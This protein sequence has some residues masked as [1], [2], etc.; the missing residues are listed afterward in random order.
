MDTINFKYVLEIYREKNITRAAKK[1]YVSQPALSQALNRIEKLYGIKIFDK[2]YNVTKSGEIFIK[3]AEK[4]N[5]N[6]VD[7]EEELNMCEINIGISQFYVKYLLNQILATMSNINPQLKIHVKEDISRY[8]EVDFARGELDIAF[9]PTPIVNNLNYKILFNEKLLLCMPMDFDE[10]YL[11]NNKVKVF[12][13]NK[14]S[15]LRKISDEIIEKME[16]NIEDIFEVTNLDDINSMVIKKRGV[17]ILPNIIERLPGV[18]YIETDYNR[19]FAIVYK[20]SEKLNIDAFI[21]KFND[22]K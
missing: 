14:G 21:K 3:Y 7:L 9:M 11:I 19:E 17:A 10:E 4:I 16:I 1:L 13:M 22:I 5:K 2:D 12:A 18:K 6:M 15:K 8:L 20:N